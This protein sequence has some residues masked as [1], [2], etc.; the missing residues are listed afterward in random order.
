MTEVSCCPISIVL[1]RQNVTN[2]NLELRNLHWFKC[3]AK[4]SILQQRICIHF[5]D[6]TCTSQG[7]EGTD[8]SA[9]FHCLIIKVA[10]NKGRSGYAL[11]YIDVL[12]QLP[13]SSPGQEKLS[14]RQSTMKYLPSR[15]HLLCCV[16]IKIKITNCL[17]SIWSQPWFKPLHEGEKIYVDKIHNECHLARALVA[18]SS[19]TLY[20]TIT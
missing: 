5:I 18:S 17:G 19:A 15:W 4:K 2:L 20:A 9:L 7:R 1:Y 3:L 16:V 12:L 13:L 6:V 8:L 14:S 10:C 11:I